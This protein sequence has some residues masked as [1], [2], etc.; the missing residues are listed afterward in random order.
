M[1]DA[2]GGTPPTNASPFSVPADIKEVY[3]HFGDPAKF[4]AVPNAASLPS[5]D[6]W[7]GRRL[8]AQDTGIPWVYVGGWKKASELE[9][10]GYVT[11]TTFGTGWA[12]T[13]GHA[14]RIRKIGS[15]V[16]LYGAVTLGSG[17][18][19]ANILTI[20]AGYRLGGAY[21]NWFV[22]AAVA[23]NGSPHELFLSG[24]DHRLSVPS[25]YRG[26]GMA[27]GDVLPL[28]GSWFVN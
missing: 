18:L 26:T 6:N 3:D 11:L 4:W 2:T 14:P 15:Q 24:V 27:S 12:A 5:T 10:S 17:G 25:T 22:N 9:D 19:Y 23:S 13:A 20:P 28:T 7:D 21:A 1:A 16:F 8:I